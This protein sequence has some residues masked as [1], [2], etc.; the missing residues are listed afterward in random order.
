MWPRS[1]S[2]MLLVSGNGHLGYFVACAFDHSKENVWPSVVRLGFG[3]LPRD[4]EI[5][6]RLEVRNQILPGLL[7]ISSG[8]SPAI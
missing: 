8:S 5:T 7:G 6:L 1:S 4:V 2:S 3:K